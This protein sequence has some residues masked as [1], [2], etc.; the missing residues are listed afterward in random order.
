MREEK[1]Q[2]RHKM[3]NANELRQRNRPT[4]VM[5]EESIV[6]AEDDRR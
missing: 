2:R 3:I 4:D 5:E 6:R 1:G